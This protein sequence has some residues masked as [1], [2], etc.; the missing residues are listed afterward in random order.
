MPII[1]TKMNHRELQLTN[2]LKSKHN[3]KAISNIVMHQAILSPKMKLFEVKKSPKSE[4][5]L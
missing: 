5:V 3:P 1:K 4:T 2:L